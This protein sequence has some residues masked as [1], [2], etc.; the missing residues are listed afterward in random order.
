MAPGSPRAGADALLSVQVMGTPGHES[1]ATLGVDR[2]PLG[3]RILRGGA[4]WLGCWVVG[5]VALPIPVV[6]LVVPL[7]S[8]VAGPVAGFL[9]G[10][11]KGVIVRGDLICADCRQS[12][13]MDG[14]ELRFP[15]ERICPH[16]S[17]H[18]FVDA[19]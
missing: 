6:H 4:V 14:V 19:A 9:V 12:I 8:A 15:T 11:K 13:P 1:S 3:K 16:C 17:Q 5:V 18:L 2:W 10:R 7:V